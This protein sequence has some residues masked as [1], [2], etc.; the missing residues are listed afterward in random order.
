MQLENKRKFKH[1]LVKPCCLLLIYIILFLYT[2]SKAIYYKDSCVTCKEN[3]SLYNDTGISVDVAKEMQDTNSEREK[4]YNFVVWGEKEGLSISNS[5]LMKSEKVTLVTVCGCTDIICKSKIPLEPNDTE[6]CLM[7]TVTAYNVFGSKDITNQSVLVEGK[8]YIV[9]GMITDMK[10][11]IIIE[12]GE[13][14]QILNRITIKSKGKNINSIA[15]NFKNIFGTEGLLIDTAFLYDVLNL[16]FLIV[17]FVFLL[18]IFFIFG[19]TRKEYVTGQKQHCL[20]NNVKSNFFKI[21][22]WKYWIL[23]ILQILLISFGVL[24]ILKRLSFMEIYLPTKWSDF[25]YWEEFFKERKEVLYNIFR[26]QKM[27]TEI[28]FY[29]SFYQALFY[30]MVTF[31]FSIIILTNVKNIILLMKN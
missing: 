2:Y 30:Y 15:N 20:K 21:Y 1:E 19:K 9:R 25:A 16:I 24:L 17:P 18:Y 5:E 4:Q 8:Q 10:N 29:L 7:D 31:L 26:L 12:A 13:K 23:L 28:N 6:G 3:I 14:E 11:V 27:K 22:T